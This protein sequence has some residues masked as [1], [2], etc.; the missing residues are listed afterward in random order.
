[1]TC[2]ST[3]A[4]LGPTCF[5]NA[6]RLKTPAGEKS[7]SDVKKGDLVLTDGDEYTPVLENIYVP[8]EHKKVSIH[9]ERPYTSVTVTENHWMFVKVKDDHLCPMKASQLSKGM[10]IPLAPHARGS[11][12]TAI[13]EIVSPGKWSLSTGSCSVYAN[14]VLTGTLCGNASSPL[15]TWTTMMETRNLAVVDVNEGGQMVSTRLANEP[16]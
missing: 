11:Q 9:F 4:V 5:D 16:F 7:I 15:Y 3:C 13:E 2:G 8:G 14:D 10:P 6:T 1:V 12:V